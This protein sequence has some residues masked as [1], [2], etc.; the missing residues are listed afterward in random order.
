MRNLNNK[1]FTLVE[2]LAVIAILI[3]IALV[4]IPN[5][6]SSIER[7]KDKQ[8][9]AIKRVI[10]S[11]GDLYTSNNKSKFNSGGNCLSVSILINEDYLD[12]ADVSSYKDKFLYYTKDMTTEKISYVGI[13]DN[14]AGNIIS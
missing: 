5:I 7:T 9:A 10:K 1:G 2:L 6:S 12:E 14:C 13:Q 3:I 11:A 8:D 4:A